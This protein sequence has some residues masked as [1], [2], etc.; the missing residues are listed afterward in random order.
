MN[1]YVLFISQIMGTYRPTYTH[2][3]MISQTPLV[4][5]PRL[6]V[7]IPLIFQLTI[8]IL[9]GSGSCTWSALIF[10]SDGLVLPWFGCRNN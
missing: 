4:L 8:L 1:M 6:P 10:F 5:S 3:F 9:C 2:L 7:S